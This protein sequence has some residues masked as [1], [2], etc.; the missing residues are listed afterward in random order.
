MAIE[1]LSA[2]TTREATS[3]PMREAFIAP[4]MLP[5]PFVVSVDSFESRPAPFLIVSTG[6]GRER[7]KRHMA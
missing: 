6:A 5:P 7:I 3:T 1:T 4:K 2:Q